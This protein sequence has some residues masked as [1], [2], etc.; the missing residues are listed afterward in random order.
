VPFTAFALIKYRVRPIPL[1]PPSWIFSTQEAERTRTTEANLQKTL[2]I[3]K[4]EEMRKLLVALDDSEG[5]FKAVE[6]VGRQFGGISDLHVTL[7]HVLPGLPPDFWDDGHILTEKEM[8]ERR[9]VIDRWLT[10]LKARLEPVFERA[11][12]ALAE[13]GIAPH[14][15]KK[16]SSGEP[17]GVAD[18]ILA[19]ARNGGYDTLVMGRCGRSHT[20]HE[21]MGSIAGKVINHGAGIAICIVE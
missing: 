18:T 9:T 20:A 16:K 7:F 8:D 13:H 14:Q 12:A 17:V 10:N 21:L 19:E 3:H 15:M 6:Y 2:S 11:M 4:G 1:S 5:S